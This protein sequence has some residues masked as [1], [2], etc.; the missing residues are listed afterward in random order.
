[1]TGTVL[2]AESISSGVVVNARISRPV[3]DSRKT[4]LSSILIARRNF[5]LVARVRRVLVNRYKFQWGPVTV[6]LV[7]GHRVLIAPT[8]LALTLRNKNVTLVVKRH[9][10]EG[11]P[12]PEFKAITFAWCW[13]QYPKKTICD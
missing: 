7:H 2:S 4:Y 6:R 5:R 3:E 1:M 12:S 8:L 10:P 9:V 13:G 11:R